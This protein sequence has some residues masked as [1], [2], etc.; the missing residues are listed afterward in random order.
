M[1]Q[2]NNIVCPCGSGLF[3]EI[4]LAYNMGNPVKKRRGIR[5]A[6][7]AFD[8]KSYRYVLLPISG[9]NHWSFVIIENATQQGQAKAYHINSLKGAH[10]T[11]YIFVILQWF[12]AHAL[13]INDTSS[14]VFE[15]STYAYKTKPQQ[16]NC[17]DCGIY[18]LFYMDV[19]ASMISRF[20]PTSITDEIEKWTRGGLNTTKAENFRALLHKKIL[21]DMH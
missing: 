2:K 8:W 6:I 19:I 18:M 15:W 5:A 1:A 3:G 12:F 21:D 17:L 9:G 10:S 20:E 14:P 7:S 16:S 13:T 11:E 4:E